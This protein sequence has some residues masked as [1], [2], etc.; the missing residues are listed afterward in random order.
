MRAGVIRRWAVVAAGLTV[1]CAMPVIASAR[2]ASVPSLTAGQ[3]RARILASAGQ[4]YAGYAESNATFGLPSLP[5]LNGVASLLDGVTKM[6]VWVAAPDDWRVDVLSDAGE[7]DTYQ[8]GTLSYIWDSGQELLT[9][10]F[11]QPSL[12][13][14]RPADLVPPALAVRLLEAAGQQARFSLIPAQRVGRPERGR[15]ARA[16]R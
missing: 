10:V 14:P 2:P 5:G 3:L 8:L 4:S 11:G 13:L 16:A 9:E 7:R 6:R 15:A 12:R 1:L